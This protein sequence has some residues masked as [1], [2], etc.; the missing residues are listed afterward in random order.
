MDMGGPWVD[1][2]KW[3]REMNQEGATLNVSLSLTA[4][5]SVC[6]PVVMA[7]GPTGKV[8]H[9]VDKVIFDSVGTGERLA[10]PLDAVAEAEVGAN[11]E[12]ARA[13]YLKMRLD[14][15]VHVK[16]SSEAPAGSGIGSSSAM[17]VAIIEALAQY[18]DRRYHPHDIVRMAREIEGEIG[19]LGGWQDYFPPVYGPGVHFMTWEP[20][21]W[22]GN[23]YEKVDVPEGFIDQLNRR[24][25]IVYSGRSRLSG[26]IHAYVYG[27]LEMPGSGAVEAFSAMVEQAYRCRDAFRAGDILTICNLV[28]ASWQ[29]QKALHPSVTN[30]E[31]DRL[32]EVAMSNGAIAGKAGG[33]GGGGCLFLI[34]DEGKKADLA[35]A[36]SGH[37]E[38]CGLSAKILKGHLAA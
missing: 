26:D 4:T 8:G 38:E 16:T 34:A 11:M 20:G 2:D 14:C 25:L 10:I 27:E 1:V 30:A 9:P 13:A 29:C 3:R 7:S 5:V 23:L 22:G 31:I 12:L 17:A 19:I 24:S 18:V 35:R 33:A 21:P 15:P 6:Q 28:N 32:F 36:L 37:F